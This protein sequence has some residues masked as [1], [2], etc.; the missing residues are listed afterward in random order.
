MT[1]TATAT[2]VDATFTSDTVLER[3]RALLPAIRDRAAQSEHDRTIPKESVDEFLDAG[4]ARIL[5]PKMFGGAEL[6][7]RTWI[8]VVLEISAA[9]AAHG[10]CASLLIHH[11]HYYA[12]FP[13][14]AQAAVWADGPDVPI[15][16]TLTP[17][18]KIDFVDGGYRISGSISYLSGVNHC[19]WIMVGGMV[20][21]P[22]REPEWTLFAVAPGHYEVLDTW[23]TVGMRGTG[24]NTVVYE[25]V[26]VP[27]D[28]VLRV[29]DM[30]D[31]TS[32]GG[33]LHESSFFRAPW[34]TYAPLTFVAP[35][36][37]AA[38]GA[39]ETYRAWTAERASLF[40]SRVADYTSIQTRMARAAASLDAA[41]L[42]MDRAID[43]ADLPEPAPTSLRTRT[44]RDSGRMSELIVEAMDTIMT[45]SGSAGFTVDS[46]IQRAWRDVHF[47]SSHV[48]LNPETSFAAW[49][50]E[51]FGLPR[52][53][54][55]RLY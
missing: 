23:Q 45:I 42:L 20:P 1:A 19:T 55:Q 47:A 5:A 2:K 25:D 54:V 44:Y 6:G 16:A 11:P 34:I 18:S 17:A 35:M 33:G 38:R 15:A 39:L 51:Q 37:G 48:I 14:G 26:F 53:P 9:D 43:V 36:L 4:I 50:R 32:P 24:S 13:K 49:G 29:S 46:S 31:G 8:D 7:L 10:W 40:G 21:V 22:G 12:Q 27:A 52:D 3:V 28:H 30:R 41:G